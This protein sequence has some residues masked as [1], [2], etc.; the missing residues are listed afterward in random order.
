MGLQQYGILNTDGLLSLAA[1]AMV[2]YLLYRSTAITRRVATS[3]GINA[4]A[5][6]NARVAYGIWIALVLSLAISRPYW[7]AEDIKIS[8]RGDDV[9]FLVDISRSMYATDIPPS[10]LE[11]AKRKIKDLVAKLSLSGQA[12]RFGITVF[13]GNGYTVCP[14]TTD[15]GVLAQFVETIS[16][17]LVSSLGSNL[18]AGIEAAL[19]RF[20]D[21]AKSHSRVVVI[22][23]GEDDFFDAR[24]AVSEIHSKGVRFDV[25]GL[26][27]SQGSTIQL[28]N[29]AMLLDQSSRPVVS[30]LKEAP[31]QEIARAGG[32]VYVKASLDDS[33]ISALSSPRITAGKDSRVM[34]DSSIRTYRELGPWLVVAALI[35][36]VISASFTGASPFACIVFLLCAVQYISPAAAQGT[37]QAVKTATHASPFTLYEQGDYQAA[38]D[39]FAHELHGNP[40]DRALKHG[41]ASSLYR[42]GRYAESEQ[43]FSELA[44]KAANGRHYYEAIYNQANAQLKMKRYQEAIDSF[45][46]ALDVKPDDEQASHNLSVARALLEEEKRRALEPT[47]TP[48]AT[49]TATPTSQSQPSPQSSPSASP[50]PSQQPSPSPQSSPEP[51]GSPEQGTPNPADGTAQPTSSSKPDEDMT[52]TSTTEPSSPREQPTGVATAEASATANQAP[53]PAAQSEERLKEALDKESEPPQSVTAPT[54]SAPPE[55]SS[56][57]EVEAWLESLP[58]SPLLIR[59]HRGSPP[60]NGQT[61]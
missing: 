16:P 9:V 15:R 18:K 17:D 33:D 34:T 19:S 20:D 44:T 37:P 53:S 5:R 25:L 29:G 3:L 24:S 32:G 31:L 38:A 7:G 1:I 41:L 51:S 57:P 45:L 40:S 21:A 23:D 6:G 10:R 36:L 4:P 59:R 46:K 12:A 26:G 47:P 58:E 35:L 50:E 28:P 49:P 8:S 11:I 22:S 2:A 14:I 13:A 43:I 52:A 42:L 56:F 27:T 55:S 48:T 61:W 54:A 30:M 39:G 60:S